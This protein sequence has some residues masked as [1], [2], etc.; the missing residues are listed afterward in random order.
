VTI[1]RLLIYTGCGVVVA[2][3]SVFLFVLEPRLYHIFLGT[4]VALVFIFTA[5]ANTKIYLVIRKLSRSPNRPHD[6]T[7]VEN[8]TKLKVFLGEIKHAKSCF[9]VVVCFC[10]LCFL[11]AATTLPFFP[12][13]EQFELL[14]ITAWI[15]TLGFLNST[16]NS[17]IF[18]W[19]KTML[20]KEAVK[21]LNTM[22]SM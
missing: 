8:T 10:V 19:T 7:T 6:P 12:T 15:Y 5:F 22:F 16:V 17:I 11:P 3:S 9:M 4:L 2:I 18:F 1:K 21:R 20:R 14:A 13:L